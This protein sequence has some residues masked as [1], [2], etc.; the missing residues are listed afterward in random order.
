LG[1]DAWSL[2]APGGVPN[3][4]GIRELNFDTT[5]NR[6]NRNPQLFRGKDR[7]DEF[8]EF[9]GGSTDTVVLAG[10]SRW[11]KFFILKYLNEF[12]NNSEKYLKSNYIEN[13]GIVK[14]IVEYTPGTGCRIIPGET[15]ILYQ[16]SGNLVS[17]NGPIIIN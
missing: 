11:F 16:P 17:E 9:M 10:H 2:S 4:D 14:L 8:C 15:E 7:L 5:W 12:S 1:R 3:V 6:G 13:T